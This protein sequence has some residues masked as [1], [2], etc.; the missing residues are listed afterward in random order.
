[1]ARSHTTIDSYL[2]SLPEER[3]EALRKVREV[4]LKYLPEGYEETMDFGMPCY[5]IPLE[6][7][8][9]TYNGHPLMYAAFASQKNYM[10]L[11]LMSVYGS[12][13]IEAWFREAFAKAGKKLD[14]GKSCVRFKKLE[15]LP[16]DIIGQ[17]IARV[18]VENY[19]AHYEASRNRG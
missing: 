11:Y 19:I 5:V 12:P 10:A 6:R 18:S 8:P 3:R 17:T 9:K 16:L 1:M 2:E 14:M 15:D 13:N 4:I 7:F